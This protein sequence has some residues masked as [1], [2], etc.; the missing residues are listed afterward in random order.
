VT[1]GEQEHS[2]RPWGS[3]TVIDE[4]P[5]YRVKR[6]E[7]LPRRRLS[8]QRHAHRTEH[9]FVV[10]GAG[11][12]MLE[13]RE[14]DVGVGDTAEIPAGAAHRAA[15]RGEELFVF[16]EVAHGDYVGEDDIIRLEDD[17]GRISDG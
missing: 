10:G 4:G 17:F 11:T 13:G 12:V 16:I 15:N 2:E 3:Y 1:T 9:W 8:Y 6:I 5:G 7:I 14:I